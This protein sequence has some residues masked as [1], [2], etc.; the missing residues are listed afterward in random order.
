MLYF[1]DKV[2][3]VSIY[4]VPTQSDI[5]IS[6]NLFRFSPTTRRLEDTIFQS[7]V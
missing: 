7:I 6:N 3:R 2:D 4:E 1:P 5:R